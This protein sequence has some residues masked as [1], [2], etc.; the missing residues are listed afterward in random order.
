MYNC[1]ITD[2]LF[3]FQHTITIDEG[4]KLRKQFQFSRLIIVLSINLDAD[5][6]IH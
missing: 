5:L 6:Y 2:S 4:I 3:D 1:Y